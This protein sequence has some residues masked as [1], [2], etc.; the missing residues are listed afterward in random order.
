MKKIPIV[1]AFDNNIVEPACIC[2]FSLLKNAK[3]D[4]FYNIY[5]LHSKSVSLK[6][7]KLDKIPTIFSNCSIEYR[8][9]DDT[10]DSAY[11]VRGVTKATYYRLMIPSI[12]PDHKKVI[13][14]DVDI[15]FRMDLADLYNQDISSYYLAATLDLGLNQ[16]IKYLNSVPGLE[17]GKYIQAGFLVL[18]LEKMRQD[19]IEQVFKE[20]AKHKYKYQDQDI[21]NI[22]CKG[23]IKFLKPKYNLNDCAIINMLWH[24]DRLPNT[25]TEN[26]VNSALTTG[27]IHYSGA[28]PWNKYSMSFDIWWEYYRKSPFFDENHYH[29]FFFDKTML[30]ESLSL[31]KR[32]KI[33]IR[34][35]VFGRYKGIC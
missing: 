7:D 20:L 4:T 25:I 12:L 11:E 13:Y 15:I 27:N 8:I 3:D 10:F 21:L 31:W 16:E 32:I 28:K 19:N 1:F 29:K 5:I 18:N 24:K 14:S 6:K 23:H 26:D 34:Y 17:A 35:F 9:V 33:L 2:I 30:L 22:T